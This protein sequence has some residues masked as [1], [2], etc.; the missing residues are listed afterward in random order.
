M[1][2][3]YVFVPGSNPPVSAAE[4]VRRAAKRINVLAGEEALSAA[5]A[6]DGLQLLNDMLFAFGPKGIQYVHTTLAATDTLNFPDEQIRNVVLMLCDDLADDFGMPISADL[7]EDIR[8]ARLEL[9]A[10]FLTIN[11]AV[12]DRALRVRR[13]G[14]YDWARGQ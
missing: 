6:T 12:P 10:A 4:V 14:F 1:T 11:P 9:Q 5:E 2:V 3:P 7:R 8:Q 13:P